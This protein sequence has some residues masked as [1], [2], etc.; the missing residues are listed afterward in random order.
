MSDSTAQGAETLLE[1]LPD[2][3]N[4]LV[5]SPS[6]SGYEHVLCH[7]LFGRAPP[8]ELNI[9]KISYR[10]AAQR[11]L[12]E[13]TDAFEDLPNQIAVIGSGDFKRSA[14]ATAPEEP[15][16]VGANES[17]HLEELESPGDLTGLGILLTEY[18][19]DFAQQKWDSGATE[20]S[21]CFDSLTYLLQYAD[22]QRV[23]RFLHVITN[24]IT[25]EGALAH[26]HVD[27]VA[28]EP[29]TLGTLRALFDAVV[30]TTTGDTPD[31]WEVVS[32]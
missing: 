32:R 22:L 25:S 31:E 7:T 10:Q 16:S 27:P 24:R 8:E 11:W 9:L 2:E 3:G 23:F 20:M 5:L 1:K 17:I 30:D 26:Y 6:I 12:E 4:I 21:V 29:Q 13:Y 15:R 19:N 14:A 28:H 18:L